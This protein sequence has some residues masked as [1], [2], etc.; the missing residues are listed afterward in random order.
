MKK[1]YKYKCPVCFRPRPF[2]IPHESCK[3]FINVTI[4][5]HAIHPNQNKQNSQQP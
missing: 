2:P 1:E 5:K 4:T 3:Q